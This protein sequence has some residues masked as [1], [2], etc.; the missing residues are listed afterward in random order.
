M[1]ALATVNTVLPAADTVVANPANKFTPDK[2]KLVSHAAN[3]KEVGAMVAEDTEVPPRALLNI[4]V[5][6]KVK[7]AAF[8]KAVSGLPPKVSVTFV[9]SVLESTAPVGIWLVVA[10]VPEV[11]NVTLVTP[12]MVKLDAKAPI[13]AKLPASVR[14]L[15]PLLMPVPPEELPNGMELSVNPPKVGV[16]PK[17]I[18]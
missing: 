5:Q 10:R 3:S 18:S 1:Y 16:L 4:P 14:V 13:V 11:G 6:P 2:F 9:S 17:A 7:D 12:V 8:T 15:D